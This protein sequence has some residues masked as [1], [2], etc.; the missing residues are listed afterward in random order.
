[1]FKIYLLLISIVLMFFSCEVTRSEDVK[2]K[3]GNESVMKQVKDSFGFSS[4]EVKNVYS[5]KSPS[6]LVINLYVS[7]KLKEQNLNELA[8]VVLSKIHESI[9]DPSK[10]SISKVSF[11]DEENSSNSMRSFTFKIN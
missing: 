4:I 2:F 9:E 5:K 10:F 1:M 6:I 11:F 3:L 7:K 8:Q